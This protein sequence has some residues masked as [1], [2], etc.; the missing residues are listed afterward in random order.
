MTINRLPSDQMLTCIATYT[1][2]STCVA[3]IDN[4]DNIKICVFVFFAHYCS[5]NDE[6][7]V[8]CRKRDSYLE[9][10]IRVL[11]ALSAIVL[12]AEM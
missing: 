3:T 10:C 9:Q 4:D 2:C 12:I 11:I 8:D 1:P 6:T 7:N 5:S